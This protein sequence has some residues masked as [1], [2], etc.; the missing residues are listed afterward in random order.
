MFSYM[1]TEHLQIYVQGLLFGEWNYME[2]LL[3]WCSFFQV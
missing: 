2:A 1:I 3:V